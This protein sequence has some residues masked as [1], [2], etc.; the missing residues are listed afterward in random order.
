MAGFIPAISINLAPNLALLGRDYRIA[1]ISS[2][3]T[4]LN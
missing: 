1:G 4:L 3:M 2:A